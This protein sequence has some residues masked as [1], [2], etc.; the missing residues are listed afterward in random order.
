MAA[1]ATP[2]GLIRTAVHFR[3][4]EDPGRA[5]GIEEEGK[6]KNLPTGAFLAVRW[7]KP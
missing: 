3:K 5:A 1:L 7:E 4:E 6:A 2:A